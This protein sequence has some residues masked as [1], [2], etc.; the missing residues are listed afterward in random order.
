MV[1]IL[2]SSHNVCD[3]MCDMI[4]VGQIH[5][6]IH[7]PTI[8]EII[9][10]VFLRTV[11]CIIQSNMKS[12]LYILV[13]FC[14]VNFVSFF[15]IFSSSSPLSST[16]SVRGEIISCPGCKLNRLT[17]LRSFLKDEKLGA[18]E[19][20]NISI[21]WIS[22][23]N[24]TLHIYDTADNSLKAT[25]DLALL[26]D[27]TQLHELFQAKGFHK[28]MKIDKNLLWFQLQSLESPL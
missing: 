25:I 24:P 13:I 8:R 11:S 6:W 26:N 15:C 28:K 14:I 18:I 22:G 12:N 17:E 16:S 2:Y 9:S 3:Y 27:K 21:Q 1:S 19:Y 20:E 5:Y 4:G 10:L 7:K 23:H